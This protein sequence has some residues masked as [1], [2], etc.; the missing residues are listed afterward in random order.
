[1]MYEML[2]GAVYSDV[3]L[4]ANEWPFTQPAAL[5]EYKADEGVRVNYEEGSVS[6]LAKDLITRMPELAVDIR[7]HTW[8]EVV[9]W[10][11]LEAKRIR[12]PFIPDVNEYKGHMKS[13]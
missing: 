12:A 2:T 8:F 6:E 7:A 1:M 5:C 10:S 13:R 3:G 11:L 9:D 4:N